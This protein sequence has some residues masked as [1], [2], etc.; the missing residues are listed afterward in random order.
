MT[1][2]LFGPWPASRRVTWCVLAFVAAVIFGPGFLVSL[3]PPPARL[4]DFYQEY[5]SA[6][7]VLTGRPIYTDQADT[8]EEYVGYRRADYGPYF[9]HRNA[10][11]PPSVL[12]A[13]PLARL[14]YSD[15]VLTWDLVSLALLAAAFGL[16]LWQLEAPFA[17]WSVL[18]LLV[19]LLLCNV[20][21]QQFN[22]GQLNVVLLLLLTGCWAADRSGRPWLAGALL[23]AATALKLFPGFLFVLF[24]ARRDVRAVA[25]GLG[26][27]AALTGLTA[28]VLGMEC[29][30]AYYREVLPDVSRFRDEWLNS[31][32]LGF[33]CK[34]L[35]ARSGHTIPLAPMP[36]LAHA[37]T[38]TCDAA[39]LGVLLVLARRS[40]TLGER[41]LTFGLALNAMLLI[42]PIAWDHYFLL[43][44]L[45]AL[46]LWLRLRGGAA[47]LLRILLLVLSIGPAWLWHYCIPGPGEHHGQVATPAQSL[48]PLAYLFY[49]QLGL[50]ALTAHTL[51]REQRRS[52]MSSQP[53]RN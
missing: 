20:L 39:V 6:R 30:T 14:S 7:N 36:R 49:A 26:T 44:L 16:I 18:P 52:T 9:I 43:L 13:L 35:E 5:A 29:F 50:F 48:G 22:Q 37:L 21:R 42:S 32:F 40:R 53:S 51:Y 10:H 8:V 27:I 17:P 3:R 12:L 45:P 38:L 33:W 34:L 15:A 4:V 41:D 28:A 24:A 23:G 1:A 47:V 31:S 25:S 46:L 19:A 11:P 2:D